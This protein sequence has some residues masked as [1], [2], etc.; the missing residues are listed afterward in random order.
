MKNRCVRLLGGILAFWPAVASAQLRVSNWNVTNYSSGR[1]SAFQ[2]AIYGVYQDRTMA[3]DVLIGQEFLSAAGVNA[4]LS[5][6]NTAPGSPGDWAAAQFID[7][8]D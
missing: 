8:P 3:P 4:F 6:L 7:G 2:T 5:L 1:V